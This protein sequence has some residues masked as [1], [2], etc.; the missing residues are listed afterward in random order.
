MLGLAACSGAHEPSRDLT[1]RPAR[2]LLGPET[3]GVSVPALLNL[4]IDEMSQR[5]GPRLPLPA[6]FADPT[7][8]LLAQRHESMDSAAL[9]RC[10]GLALVASYD[11]RSRQVS[12]LLLLGSDEEALMSRARLELGAERYLVLPV[13]QERHPTR[14]LGLRVL[15]IGLTQ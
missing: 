7:L 3:A 13:F 12:D 2:P 4:S 15:A 9:F 1:V 11:H 8:V 10:R 14:L 5:L 6:G